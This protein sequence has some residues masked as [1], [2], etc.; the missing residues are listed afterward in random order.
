MD[1]LGAIIDESADLRLCLANPATGAI[2]NPRLMETLLARMEVAPELRQI[3]RN[4]ALVVADHR[5]GALLPDIA[6]SYTQR[7]T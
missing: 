4:F 1:Q 7:P 2:K 3:L 6:V 5:R